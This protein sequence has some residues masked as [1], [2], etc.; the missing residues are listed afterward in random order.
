MG[1]SLSK[2]QGSTIISTIAKDFLPTE[3]GKAVLVEFSDFQC[4]ACA[5]YYPL[6]KQLKAE[7]GDKLGVVYRHFPLRNIHK[8]ADL[9]ARASEAA[10]NQD[11]FWEMHDMIF[12]NQKE[13]STSNNALSL[14]TNYA[15]S[16]GLDREKF[17]A[18]IDSNFVYDK[19]N[20]NYQEGLSLKVGGTPTFFLNGKKIINP[21]SYNEFKLLIQNT[22]EQ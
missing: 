19:V 15:V 8:N 13:W 16:L 10:L 22:L 5:I 2:S 20:S 9:A 12:E 14:F 11:K 21:R 1:N 17:L 3:E 6:V 7:F 18:D 4:P